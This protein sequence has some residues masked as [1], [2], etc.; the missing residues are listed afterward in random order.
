MVSLTI[1]MLYRLF[2]PDDPTVAAR[3]LHYLENISSWIED[4]HLRL[5]WQTLNFL[6]SLQLHTLN[7]ISQS[8]WDHLRLAYVIQ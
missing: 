5:I 8:N 3:V 2:H 6:P 1:V 7:T 4:H